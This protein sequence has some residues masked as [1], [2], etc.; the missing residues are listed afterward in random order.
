LPS[1]VVGG[2]L[3]VGGVTHGIAV[4]VVKGDVAGH[5]VIL[6][7]PQSGLD[8][9]GIHGIGGLDGLQGY[10]VSIVAHSGDS[11]HGVVA[12]VGVQ[13]AGSGVDV[14]LHALIESGV[15]ALLIEGGDIQLDVGALGGLQ[16]HV[17]VQ[18]IGAHEGDVQAQRGGL[19]D[20]LGGIGDGH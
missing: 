3:D 4:G 13:S 11:S 2:V 7:I 10:I 17:V 8:G 16:H 5:A 19:S 15:A 1:A 9:G 20:D 12:A 6:H 14:V 18:G